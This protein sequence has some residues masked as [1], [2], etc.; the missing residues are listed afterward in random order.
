MAGPDRPDVVDGAAEH[1]EQRA[2]PCHVARLSAHHQGQRSLPGAL[3]SAGDGAV[4]QA[5]SE[6]GELGSQRLRVGRGAG[7]AV[8]HDAVRCQHRDGTCVPQQRFTHDLSVWKHA[9]HRGRPPH[10]FLR[11]SFRDRASVS[12]KSRT[13][14]FRRIVA[15]HT[16]AV[17]RKCCSHAAAHCAE[18]KEGDPR[19]RRNSFCR[20]RFLPRTMRLGRGPRN[21]FRRLFNLLNTSRGGSSTG[22]RRLHFTSVYLIS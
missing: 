7:R 11:R 15:V 5:Y 19:A 14:G 20:H 22:Q 17:A 4:D 13:R 10:R 6:R 2:N 18:A 12:G 9:D 21:R 8:E 16:E 3:N 1:I